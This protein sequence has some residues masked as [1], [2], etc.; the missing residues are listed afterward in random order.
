MLRF[1]SANEVLPGGPVSSVAGTSEIFGG[2]KTVALSK[3]R[4]TMAGV[5]IFGGALQSARRTLQHSIPPGCDFW[6]A[7]LEWNGHALCFDGALVTV[8]VSTQ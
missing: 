1:S 7:G 6:L 4:S 5:R 2:D 8:A 3:P